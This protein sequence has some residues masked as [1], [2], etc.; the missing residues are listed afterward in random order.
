MSDIE[1]PVRLADPEARPEWPA[2]TALIAAL[3]LHAALL[4]WFLLGPEI[5]ATPSPPVMQVSL[6]EEPPPPPPPAPAPKP[7]PP[8]P[9]PSLAPRES[10]ADQKTTAP[11]PAQAVAPAPEA[12]PPA[13][14]VTAPPE[15]APPPPPAP[16]KEALAPPQPPEPTLQADIPPP[17]EP[18][19]K[20][21]PPL[22][23]HSAEP[24]RTALAERAPKIAPPDVERQFGETV[25]TGDPY[26]NALWSRIEHNRPATTPIGSSGLHLEGISVYELVI[27]RSGRIRQM[28]LERSSGSAQLDD[29]AKRMIV[30]AEPFPPLPPDYPDVAPLKVT[31]RLFPQ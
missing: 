5:G 16:V 6:V 24:R 2:L 13:P 12:P 20:P 4:A 27:E 7:Q 31:I 8:T 10:G 25:E 1:T 17:P 28:G 23:S 3:L 19:E 26:L 22:P 9:P 21:K 15:P 18:P 30:E 14:P 11:A 29:M